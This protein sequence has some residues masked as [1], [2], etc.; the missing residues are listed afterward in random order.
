MRVSLGFVVLLVLGWTT[1]CSG[2]EPVVIQ[3]RVLVAASPEAVGL[4]GARLAA[5]ED[6]IR[7]ATRQGRFPGA[8]W[9]VARHGRIVLHGA[10]G[11]ADVES[12]TPMR[13]DTIVSIASITKPITGAAIMILWDEGKLTLEDPVALHLPA[14][15]ELRLAD[16]R[17]PATTPTIRHLLT[18]TGGFSENLFQTEADWR[19]HAD[20]TLAGYTDLIARQPLA[21][22][23]GTR[24]LYSGSGMDTLACI[25][26]VVSGQGLDEFLSSRILQ[27][28]GMKDS[29][30]FPP[31]SV[32]PRMATIHQRVEGRWVRFRRYDSDL[33]LPMAKGAGGLFSTV[34]D[35]AVHAQMLLNGGV[36]NGQTILSAR[37]VGEALR[38]QSPRADTAGSGGPGQRGAAWLV[39]P[40]VMGIPAAE[41]AGTARPAPRGPGDPQRFFSHLGAS[42]TLLVGDRDTDMVLVFAAQARNLGP[43]RQ[44]FVREALAS[45]E[46]S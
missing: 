28:L 44:N 12:G 22:E 16:G 19:R 20:L 33:R 34:Y 5:L 45:L 43:I 25:V 7:Q 10:A 36:Y 32:W 6:R 8:A 13:P 2:A 17:L 1:W 46:P 15:A 14:F 41:M 11:V 21:F 39:G 29:A 24:V 18:H 27:P 40:S 38:V 9:L 23:P 35:L 4:D 30:F 3:D 31:E 26:E 42:G 37:A